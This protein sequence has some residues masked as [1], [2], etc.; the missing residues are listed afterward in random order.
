[1]QPVLKTAY[2]DRTGLKRKTQ[3]NKTFSY[4]LI[5]SQYKASE[6]FWKVLPPKNLHNCGIQKRL[7]VHKNSR[8]M[9]SILR[10]K[11]QSVETDTT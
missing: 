4:N 3:R 8:K 10:G 2:S 5:T 1:M 7:K 11:S 6:Y 9:Q